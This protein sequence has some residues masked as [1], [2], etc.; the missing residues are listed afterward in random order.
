MTIP[1]RIIEEQ[2]NYYIID[3][4]GGPVRASTKGLLKKDKVRVCVGDMVDCEIINEDSRDGI[5]LGIHER[6]SFLKR[7]SLANLHKNLCTERLRQ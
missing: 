1:G 7:P 4:S 5:I 3:T 6:K 2:K